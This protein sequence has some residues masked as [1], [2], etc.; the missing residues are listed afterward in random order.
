MNKILQLFFAVKGSAIE[1]ARLG[2]NEELTLEG[3]LPYALGFSAEVSANPRP[4]T[5][6]E[7]KQWIEWLHSLQRMI[8]DPSA[9]EAR[10]RR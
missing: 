5:R 7:V 3:G 10:A 2:P 8:A 6:R 4:L 1:L 9:Q